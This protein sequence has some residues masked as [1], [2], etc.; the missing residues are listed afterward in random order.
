MINLVHHILFILLLA[1]TPTPL[2]P[3]QDGVNGC[4]A[5]IVILFG[6]QS[7]ACEVSWCESRWQPDAHNASDA[8]GLFQI[9]PYWHLQVLYR[10]YAE[11]LVN[12][13]DYFDPWTNARWAYEVSGEGADWSAWKASRHCWG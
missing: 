9:I 2:P 1:A 3:P 10:L 5:P 13:L 4:P 11:G 7:L 12:N 8:S 6:D